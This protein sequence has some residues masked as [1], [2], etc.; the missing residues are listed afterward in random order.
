MVDFALTDNVEVFLNQGGG[1]FAHSQ[2]LTVGIGMI[3]GLLSMETADFNGDHR[4]DLLVNDE[5]RG[6]RVLVGR[7][8]GT[9]T[10]GG[11]LPIPPPIPVSEGIAVGDVN[12]DRTIS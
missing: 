3:G 9:F 11:L 6:V 1:R 2:T 12:H 5:F 8:D 4:P 7:G 10:Q